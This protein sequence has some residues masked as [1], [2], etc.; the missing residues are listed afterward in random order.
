MNEGS[1]AHA[2]IVTGGTVEARVTFAAEAATMLLG[3]DELTRNRILGGNCA[4]L[5]KVKPDG[6]SI[7]TEQITELSAAL[8]SKPFLADRMVAVIEDANR[9][10]PQSQNKLLKTLEEPTAGTV[11]LLLSENSERLLQTIR[12]RCVVL[13]LGFTDIMNNEAD[14]EECADDARSAVSIALQHAHPLADMFAVCD[15]YSGGKSEAIGFLN[16]MEAFLRDMVVGVRNK[17]LVLDARNA[18]IA[19]KLTMNT[20]RS[21]RASLALIQEARRDIERGLSVKYSL[22]DMGVRIRQEGLYG[23][24]S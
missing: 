7:K 11:L 21:F 5:I 4:D 20:D 3:D 9:M 23:K 1:L 6:E 13:R 24:S 2:F 15:K 18:E 8:R 12:S 22:R 19:N 17:N 16:T 10:T 14:N